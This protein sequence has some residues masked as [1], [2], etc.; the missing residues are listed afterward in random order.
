MRIAAAFVLILTHQQHW[1]LY[2]LSGLLTFA[3]P[4][5]FERPLGDLPRIAT[6]RTAYGERAHQTTGWLTLSSDHA[7]ASSAMQFGYRWRFC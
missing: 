2:L 1:L 5:F 4:F 6:R 3:S 7:R